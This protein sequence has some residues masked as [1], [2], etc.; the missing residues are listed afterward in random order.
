MN[1]VLE[2]RFAKMGARLSPAERPWRGAP[3]IDIRTAAEG[4]PRS[5]IV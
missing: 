4:E 1:E 5:G 2:R 3:R